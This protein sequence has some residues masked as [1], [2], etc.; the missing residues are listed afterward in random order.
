MKSFLAEKHLKQPKVPI[1]LIY[2]FDKRSQERWSPDWTQTHQ[3]L[4]RFIILN[5]TTVNFNSYTH[6]WLYTNSQSHLIVYIILKRK[7]F[8]PQNKGWSGIQLNRSNDENVQTMTFY[9]VFKISKSKLQSGKSSRTEEVL[10]HQRLF[11]RPLRDA[12]ERIITSHG[13]KPWLKPKVNESKPNQSWIDR[14]HDNYL[15]FIIFHKLCNVLP[16]CQ[17]IKSF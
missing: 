1:R 11:Y 2:S 8:H 17:E 16:I 3:Q 14:Q 4:Y 9:N 10:R 6:I 15:D 5:I 13:P 12:R 7:W